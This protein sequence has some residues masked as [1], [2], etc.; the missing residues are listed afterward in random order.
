LGLITIQQRFDEK[1]DF[2]VKSFAVREKYVLARQ[3][4]PKR[5]PEGLNLPRLTWMTANVGKMDSQ[6]KRTVLEETEK[7]CTGKLRR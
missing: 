4:I 6:R 7:L 3:P 1:Q 5:L 2:D